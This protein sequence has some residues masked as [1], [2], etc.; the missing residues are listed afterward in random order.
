MSAELD[1]GEAIAAA[2]RRAHEIG[3]PAYAIETVH[4][5]VVWDRKPLLRAGK[6]WECYANG[7]KHY[8]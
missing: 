1:E 3:L 7:E 8:G 5:W 4:G 6:V 2:F